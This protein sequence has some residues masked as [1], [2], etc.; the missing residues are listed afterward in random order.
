MLRVTGK[1]GRGCTDLGHLTSRPMLLPPHWAS[2]SREPSR[3]CYL[4]LR[5]LPS[6]KPLGA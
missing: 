4:L 3:I 6:V 5:F 1:R 2:S